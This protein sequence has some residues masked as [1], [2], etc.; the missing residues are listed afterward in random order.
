MRS[1][2]IKETTTGAGTAA[3]NIAL[4]AVSGFPRFSN[5]Y[6]NGDLCEYSILDNSVSPPTPVESGIGT[7]KST[8]TIDR[9]YPTET[10][11]GTTTLTDKSAVKQTL[12]NGRVYQVLNAPLSN[13]H[14]PGLLAV[15]NANSA[16]RRIQSAHQPAFAGSTITFVALRLYVVPFLL[17]S[18]KAPADIACRISTAAAAGK[19]L[20][21]ALYRIN[22]A[23]DITDRL[24]ESGN[25]VADTTGIKS[26]TFAATKRYPNGWYAVGAVSDG[27]PIVNS[28]GNLGNLLTTPWGVDSNNQSIAAKSTD[29]GS[30]SC[31]NPF[32]GTVTNILGNANFPNMT[33]GVDA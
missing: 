5:K 27:A 6:S 26:Y 7:Y 28:L 8:N 15:T 10:W 18:L 21:L 30:L 12:V 25:I 29:L 24:E 31:P 14:T 22:E 9:S 1:Y 19:F 16:S 17:Q 13:A 20:H 23:G 4:T 33:I 2:A 32:S 11:D 3:L